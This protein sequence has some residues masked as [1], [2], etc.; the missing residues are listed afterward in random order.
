M[1]KYAAVQSFLNSFLPAY[2]ENAIFSA[3]VAPSYPY[4]TYESIVDSFGE[5]DTAMTFSTWYKEYSWSKSVSKTR[6]ISAV[7]G[8]EGKMLECDEGY[9]LIMRGSPFSTRMGDESDDLI[10]RT[11][12][13]LTVRFYTND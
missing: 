1:N 12:F 7:I 10:K 9:V 3:P 13:N 11:F 6:D 2:E 4:I 8:R 5:T